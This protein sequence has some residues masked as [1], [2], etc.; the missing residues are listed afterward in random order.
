[1]RQLGLDISSATIGYVV[2][3]DGVI[4][5]KGHYKPTK[6]KVK[7]VSVSIA[8]RLSPTYYDM[9]KIIK[10]INPDV[11]CIEDYARK[12]SAGRSSAKTIIIL[13]CFNEVVSMACYDAITVVPIKYT[14]A[15]IRKTLGLKGK[16]EKKDVLN[17]ILEHYPDFKIELNRMNNTKKEIYD[18]ADAL[19]V[20]IHHINKK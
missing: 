5:E 16:I 20:L 10:R 15:A 12:F 17:V 18:E 6:S 19:A 1:M 14:V 11:V 8:E 7:K 4:I 3:E 13:S 9:K 2:L